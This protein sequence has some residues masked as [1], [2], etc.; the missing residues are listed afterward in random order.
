MQIMDLANTMVK[1]SEAAIVDSRALKA[2]TGFVAASTSEPVSQNVRDLVARSTSQPLTELGRHFNQA[3]SAASQIGEGFKGLLTGGSTPDN[4]LA[5]RA[6]TPNNKA[7]E[8]NLT[9]GA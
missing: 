9:R 8:Q 2:L 5:V 4:L 3:A 6:L 7:G 1:I